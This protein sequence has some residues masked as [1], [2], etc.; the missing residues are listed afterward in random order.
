[1]SIDYDKDLDDVIKEI[2][3]TFLCE[4]EDVPLLSLEDAASTDEHPVDDQA[5]LE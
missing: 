3:E 5:G 4:D 2:P 1:M